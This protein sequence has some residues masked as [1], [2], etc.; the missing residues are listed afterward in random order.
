MENA[1]AADRERHW[2]SPSGSEG[3]STEGRGAITRPRSR[4]VSGVTSRN[5]KAIRKRGDTVTSN[6]TTNSRGGGDSTDTAQGG[7]PSK[8][9]EP[10]TPTRAEHSAHA[11]LP[12]SPLPPTTTKA[13]ATAA[14]VSRGSSNARNNNNDDAE[15]S[16][17][18]ASLVDRPR[19]TTPVTPALTPALTGTTDDSDTD[20]QSAYSATPSPRES[21][22]GNF[23]YDRTGGSDTLHAVEKQHIPGSFEAPKPGI[24][25]ERVSSIMTAIPQSSPTF[26]DDTVVSSRNAVARR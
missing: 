16:S 15:S 1:L 9:K 20:F 6:R 23:D 12:P 8:S 21:L 11:D 19:T 13:T 5:L 18:A 4:N 10:R 22:R 3:E 17:I 7:S 26:S 14:A 25:R 2:K 24:V